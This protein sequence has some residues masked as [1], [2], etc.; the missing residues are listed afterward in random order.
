MLIPDSVWHVINIYK[1][2][3][4]FCAYSFKLFSFLCLS[5]SFVVSSHKKQTLFL[6]KIIHR[7]MCILLEVEPFLHCLLMGNL[8][9]SVYLS[10][11]QPSY[12]TCWWTPVS[13]VNSLY[14]LGYSIILFA[15]YFL[16]KPLFVNYL[17][18][19]FAWRVIFILGIQTRIAHYKQIAWWR[20]DPQF[21]LPLK[22]N[23][24]VIA[25]IA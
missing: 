10:C 13:S 23:R 17:Q 21:K 19:A 18:L 2:D 25:M 4:Y 7:P 9:I 22:L 20:S 11:I 5:S 6:I 3:Y 8:L 16:F 12:W 14:F 24:I 15:H 1:Q